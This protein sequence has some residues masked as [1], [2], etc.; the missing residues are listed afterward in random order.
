MDIALNKSRDALRCRNASRVIM[1][2]RSRYASTF[3]STSFDVVTRFD[4][5]RLRAFARS[6]AYCTSNAQRIASYSREFVAI[7]DVF[8]MCVSL[9][10]ARKRERIC[11]S[12]NVNDLF[13]LCASSI[14]DFN[15]IGNERDCVLVL[16]VMSFNPLF[17][18]CVIASTIITIT[19]LTT[20]AMS[21]ARFVVLI[22]LRVMAR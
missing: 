18:V 4:V 9:N 15:T 14:I 5:L 10:F 13:D 20:Y 12:F 17:V 2:S 7:H 8:L 11:L 6:F 22:K 19:I 1:S 3:A 21:F 16:R